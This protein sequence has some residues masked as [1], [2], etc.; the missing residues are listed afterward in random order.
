MRATL[1]T[2]ATQRATNQLIY[3]GAR[4]A[5]DV[6]ITIVEE[7]VPDLIAASI[8]EGEG[9]TVTVVGDDV[10]VGID[11]ALASEAYRSFLAG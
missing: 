2:A 4:R 1:S 5:Q 10:E 8:L 3:A 6:A 9:I 7:A 11:P